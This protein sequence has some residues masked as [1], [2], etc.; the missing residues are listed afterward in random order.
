MKLQRPGEGGKKSRYGGERVQEKRKGIELGNTIKV[1][2]YLASG[3]SLAELQYGY[4]IGKSTLSA[5]IQQVCQVLWRNLR[6]MVMS[7]PNPDMWIQISKE[8]ANKA[9]FPNCIGALDGKHVRLIQPPH[10]GS[11]TRDGIKSEDM[12]CPAPL[13]DINS[14]HT[15]R[16]IHEADNVRTK[17][18]NYFLC[19][20][21]YRFVE[22]EPRGAARHRAVQVLARGSERSARYR[23]VM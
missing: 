1:E 7:P 13:P 4:K 20:G 19:E 6:A 22:F 3:S 5:I 23:A 16:A 18:T 17:L 11:M 15:G 2:M 8:F 14:T 9:Y 10:S 21:R 12:N